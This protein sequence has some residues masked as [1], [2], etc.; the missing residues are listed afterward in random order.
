MSV[1]AVKVYDDRIEMAADSQTNVGSYRSASARTGKII[2][3][4]D[5]IIGIAG[6]R[7]CSL[8]AKQYFEGHP[9][10]PLTT[11]N[12]AGKLTLKF[13]EFRQWAK[14]EFNYDI[15]DKCHYLIVTDCH[16]FIIYE[17][18]AEEITDYVAIGCAHYLAE[19]GLMLGH[20]V[21]DSV[22][23]TCEMSNDCGFPVITKTIN[24]Q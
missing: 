22:A 17:T 4:I 20:N 5:C 12:K 6:S 2:E 21:K 10:L 11:S 14:N 1:V 13:D 3:G 15:Y 9:I 19:V 7:S 23:A 8:L 18:A 24:F 16:A